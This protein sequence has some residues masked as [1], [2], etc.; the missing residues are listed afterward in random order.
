M[1]LELAVGLHSEQ[2]TEALQGWESSRRQAVLML[3]I[4]M[5]ALRVR[6]AERSPLTFFSPSEA[7]EPLAMPDL[8]HHL[9]KLVNQA[10]FAK[11][12]D[13]GEIPGS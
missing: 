8:S 4:Q 12:L 9:Q 10:F 7:K 6:Q 2:K 3:L 13:A 11:Q 5:E 1:V